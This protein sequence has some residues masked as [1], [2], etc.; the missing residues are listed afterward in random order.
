[1]SANTQLFLMNLQ[2]NHSRASAYAN[3]AD[4]FRKS[5][6]SSFS[7]TNHPKT[8]QISSTSA[9]HPSAFLL[10][11]G[12]GET[13]AHFVPRSLVA[14]KLS[15]AADGQPLNSS[16]TSFISDEASSGRSEGVMP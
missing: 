15:A 9:E 2:A 1:M 5:S 11:Q 12:Y 10:R 4:Y 6:L 13:G 7:T 8:D 16:A 3:C 14:P